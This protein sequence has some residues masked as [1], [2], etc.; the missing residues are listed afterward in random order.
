MG[1]LLIAKT[2][3]NVMAIPQAK[4]TRT[5]GLDVDV[6]TTTEFQCETWDHK[7]GVADCD[8]EGVV[9]SCAKNS[10]S[11]RVRRGSNVEADC[12]TNER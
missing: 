1:L 4:R 11:R 12:G 8:G 9:R 6:T 10:L 7:Q 3:D 5:L 2:S